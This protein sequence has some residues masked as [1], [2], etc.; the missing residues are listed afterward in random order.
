ML[1]SDYLKLRTQ[2]INVVTG[3][4]AAPAEEKPVSNETGLTF[5]EELSR[6]LETKSGVDFSSHALRRIESRRIDMAGDGKLERLNRGVELAAEKGSD[7]ALVLIDS[8]AF[9][10][11]VKNN[12]V[13]T[14]MSSEDLKGNIFTN[15]DSAVII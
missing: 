14:T 4:N 15:I 13:I 12:K 8:T 5:A 1:I 3:N 6:Q 11:S 7:E 9:I 10:V 2:Q